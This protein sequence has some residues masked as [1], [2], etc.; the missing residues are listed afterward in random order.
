MTKRRKTD[1]DGGAMIYRTIRQGDV[2]SQRDAVSIAKR[3]AA[4]LGYDQLEIVAV[5]KNALG[6]WNI[7]LR[8]FKLGNKK[9][10]RDGSD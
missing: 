4:S 10:V 9:E 2:K 8:G 6:H 3:H 1:Q 5:G 7:A